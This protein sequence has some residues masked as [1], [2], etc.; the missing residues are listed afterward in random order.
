MPDLWVIGMPRDIRQGLYLQTAQYSGRNGKIT[1]IWSNRLQV[2]FNSKMQP[3]WPALDAKRCLDLESWDLLPASESGWQTALWRGKEDLPLFYRRW[4]NSGQ[5]KKSVTNLVSGIENPTNKPIRID[6]PWPTR[7]DSRH[8]R[9][10]RA[11]LVCMLGKQGR[12]WFGWSIDY[13]TRKA[14]WRLRW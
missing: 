10:I 8:Y 2:I 7:G 3:V 4:L 6:G 9:T 1:E 11:M 5:R 14:G 13:R 12:V